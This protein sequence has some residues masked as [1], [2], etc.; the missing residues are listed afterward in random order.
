VV[1][2]ALGGGVVA[3][4]TPG[5]GRCDADALVAFT[6]TG[7]VVREGTG[8]GR[9]GACAAGGGGCDGVEPRAGGPVGDGVG[10]VGGAACAGTGPLGRAG[11]TVGVRTGPLGGD[12][13]SRGTDG[14]RPEPRG[15]GSVRFGSSAVS[16]VFVPDA[17]GSDGSRVT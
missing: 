16:V 13:V 17:A 14:M 1:A 6:E 11:G 8:V 7:V 9:V 2:D 15:G 4:E 12:V 5:N 10:R 3:G